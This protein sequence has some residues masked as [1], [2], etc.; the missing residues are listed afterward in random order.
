[1]ALK[2]LSTAQ[3]QAE[4]ARR[5]KSV[6]KLEAKRGKLLA[7]LSALDAEIAQ[8]GGKAAGSGRG[9]STRG[10]GSRTGRTRPKN[11]VTLPEALADAAEAGAVLSPKEAAEI[12]QA[13]GYAT[14]SATF[15]QQVATALA[16]H[17][18]FKKVGRGQYERVG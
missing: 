7:D 16:K 3:L 18:G 13:N 10:G 6:G 4:I 8:L 1:M 15:P 9:R 2:T 11:D 5:Q 12:V 17:P 14:T